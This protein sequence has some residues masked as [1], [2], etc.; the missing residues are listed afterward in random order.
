MKIETV[1]VIKDTNFGKGFSVYQAGAVEWMWTPPKFICY[2]PNPQSDG[3]RGWVLVDEGGAL[4]NGV[5]T[6]LKETPES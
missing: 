6:Q 5:R 2:N 1:V 3:I 4:A